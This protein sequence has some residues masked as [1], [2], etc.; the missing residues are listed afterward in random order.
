[1]ERCKRIRRQNAEMILSENKEAKIY[2]NKTFKRGETIT[3]A[4]SCRLKN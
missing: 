4:E 1:M 2:K 3:E